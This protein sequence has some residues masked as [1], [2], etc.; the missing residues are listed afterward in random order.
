VE[1]SGKNTFTPWL[2]NKGLE[3]FIKMFT[4]KAVENAES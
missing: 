1:E 4:Q 3:Y 2:T